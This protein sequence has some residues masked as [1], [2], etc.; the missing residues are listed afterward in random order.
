MPADTMVAERPDV[1]ALT[2]RF[3]GLD[4]FGRLR[5]LCETVADRV[6][7]TTSLGIEDQALTH[8]IFSHDLPVDV[9]TIDTGRLF[10]ETYAVWAE[11]EERYGRKV[12]AVYPRHEAVETLTGTHGING[13][14]KSVDVRKACCGVRKV[15]PLGRALR[16]ASAWVTGL[17]ADQSAHRESLAFVTW[18]V[19][20]NVIKAN[21]LLDWTRDR[22][23]AFVEAENVPVNALHAQGFLSIGCAPCTRAIGPGEPERAGRW[24][25]ENDGNQECGLHVGPDGRLVR[26]GPTGAG[27]GDFAS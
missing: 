8:L 4:P 26:T 19:Q 20:H 21:P 16:G 25:W 14:Y 27:A 22:V 2:E 1:S 9:V 24:W 13:F 10:P 7:F 12:R 11:T 5:L 23:A 15:E 3:A 6:V 18:D 17:R